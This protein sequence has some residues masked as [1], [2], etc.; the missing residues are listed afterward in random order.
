MFRAAGFA[1]GN[2]SA[3]DLWLQNG[4]GVIKLWSQSGKG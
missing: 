2:T 1:L 3:G 4:N